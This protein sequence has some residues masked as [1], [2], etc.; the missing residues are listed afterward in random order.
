MGL[1]DNSHNK[2]D[3]KT[4]RAPLTKKGQ[5]EPSEPEGKPTLQRRAKSGA[6]S[7]LQRLLDALANLDDARLQKVISQIGADELGVSVQ[8]ADQALLTRI[9]QNM[10]EEKR[11][12]FKEYLALDQAKLPGGVLDATQGK[13]LRLASF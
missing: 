9:W 13:L 5:D 10:P 4:P 2:P 11:A 7:R 12:M 8:G 3:I 6:P 1:A